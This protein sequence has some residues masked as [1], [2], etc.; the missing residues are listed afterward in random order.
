MLKSILNKIKEKYSLEEKKGIFVS[1]FDKNWKLLLSKWIVFSDK[2]IKTQL[3]WLYNWFLKDIEKKIK[4]IVIDI[5]RNIVQLN[6]TD[7][8]L[9]TNIKKYGIVIVWV[10]KDEAGVILPDMEGVADIKNALYL[11]KKKFDITDKKVIIYRFD[12]DRIVISNY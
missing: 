5:V 1:V 3:E 10:D 12:T 4:Y 8:I 2:D 7:D 9:S 6:N 11:I